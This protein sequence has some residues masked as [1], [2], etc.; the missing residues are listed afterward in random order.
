[1]KR[2]RKPKPEVSP[3]ITAME[4]LAKDGASSDAAI[5]KRLALFAT[6]R[7]LDA[8]ETG[9]V[10][11]GR[12]SSYHL[13]QFAKKHHVSFDWMLAGDLE[14]RLRMARNEIEHQQPAQRA[15]PE[16]ASR[17]QIQFQLFEAALETLDVPKDVAD[18]VLQ[19]VRVAK[20][21]AS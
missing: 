10:M 16:L 2:T 13:G 20:E 19:Y 7:K 5:R 14:G 3:E 4:R 12:L 9:A 8:S 11:K 18:F 17:A 6:E 1:M 15:A 21:G